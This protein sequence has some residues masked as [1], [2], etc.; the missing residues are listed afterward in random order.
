MY[1]VS[2]PRIL[3]RNTVSLGRCGTH[4]VGIMLGTRLF[5]KVCNIYLY[6]DQVP[7]TTLCKPM[8]DDVFRPQNTLLV[9]VSFSNKCLLSSFREPCWILYHRHD[10][11]L[12]YSLITIGW[13][14][15]LSFT[16]ASVFLRGSGLSR[17][18]S[19][20]VGK[21]GSVPILNIDVSIGH[22]FTW[23]INH[24]SLI[25]IYYY[26]FIQRFPLDDCMLDHHIHNA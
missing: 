1:H 21:L 5:F 6:L 17:T 10:S 11:C 22:G 8:A 14:L 3:H 9:I 23:I 19:A 13:G 12:K 2:V 20:Q 7:F 24:W 25:I 26:P 15:C 16:S 18:S 4:R